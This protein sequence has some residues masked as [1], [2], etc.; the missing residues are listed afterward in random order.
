MKKANKTLRD[1]KRLQQVLETSKKKME[2][3]Q[4]TLGSAADELKSLWRLLKAYARGQYRDIP[5]KS[6][7]K[8]VAALIYF[9]AIIDA[10]PDFI[11]GVGLL[12]DISVILWTIKSIRKD[13]EK[14]RSWEKTQTKN[15]KESEA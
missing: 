9:V 8:V 2:E 6:I 3:N 7:V 15:S 1:K 5:W 12:D 13:L 10:V 14:F 4:S 11:V